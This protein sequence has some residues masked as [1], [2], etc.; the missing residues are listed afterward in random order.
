MAASIPFRGSRDYWERRY[1]KGGNSGKGSYGE[2]AE[3]K[4]EIL[5]NFVIANHIRSVIEFGCGDGNQLSLARYPQYIGIDISHTA[6]NRCREK[7]SGDST[8]LFLLSNEYNGQTAECALSLDV[9]Y[10]LVEDQVFADY[11]RNLFSS[12]SRFVVIYTSNVAPDELAVRNSQMRTHVRHRYVTGYVAEH[13]PEWKLVEN[14]PNRYPYNWETGKG[15][16][17]EFF[18][19]SNS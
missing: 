2:F 12:A 14:I 18:V 11:L 10:H 4:A 3:F 15:S 19:Y 8:K 13:Y 16:F 17:A 6:L 5:N 7:F 9:L 1:A